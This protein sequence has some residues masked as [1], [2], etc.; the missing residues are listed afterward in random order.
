MVYLLLSLPGKINIDPQRQL[1]ALI[2]WETSLRATHLPSFTA[3]PLTAMYLSPLLLPLEIQS[4]F[5]LFV[6]S[7]KIVTLSG[8]C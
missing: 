5:S 6:T 8:R 4:S 2:S 1:Q 3:Q 7:R